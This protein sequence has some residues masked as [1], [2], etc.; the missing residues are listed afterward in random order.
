MKSNNGKL[1]A[2]ICEDQIEIR[3]LTKDKLEEALLILDLSFFLHEPVCNATEINLPENALARQELKELC[4]Q[5]AEDG[6]SL[7][8]LEKSNGKPVAVLF[9]KLLFLPSPGEKDFYTKFRE[10]NTHSP[11]AQALMDFML[12]VEELHDV[13]EKF[14]LNCIYEMLFMSTSPEWGRQGIGK[15]LQQYAIQMTQELKLGLGLE[16]INPLLRSK[17]PQAITGIFSSKYSQK[18]GHAEG[19]QVVNTMPYTAFSFKGKTYA[20][21]IDPVHKYFEHMIYLV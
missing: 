8:A 12:Y 10:E 18:F 3:S 21:R 16:N 15:T 13:F 5:T 4:R 1:W 9:N 2:T 7:V 19:F 6:V 20:E 14:H 17:R 11:Q